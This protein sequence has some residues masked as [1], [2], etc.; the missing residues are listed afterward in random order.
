VRDRS[1]VRLQTKLLEVGLALD[2]VV[3]AVML[4]IAPVARLSDFFELVAAQLGK[5]HGA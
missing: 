3:I 4:V 1:Q 2:V 5:V